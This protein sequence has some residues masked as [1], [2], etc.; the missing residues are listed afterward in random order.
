MTTYLR[1]KTSKDHQRVIQPNLALKGG[2]LSLMG[3]QR[4][5]DDLT[6]QRSKASLSLEKMKRP[7]RKM[8]EG[9]FQSENFNGTCASA[10]L[11]EGQREPI[12]A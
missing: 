3:K 1:L 10:P 7:R 5:F 12:F 6:C 11:C 4:M 8:T 9:K 2:Y